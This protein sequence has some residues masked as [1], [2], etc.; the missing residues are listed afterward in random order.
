L[1]E[2]DFIQHSAWLRI[3]AHKLY[4]M[5]VIAKWNSCVAVPN[6]EDDKYF[7]LFGVKADE[8]SNALDIPTKLARNRQWQSQMRQQVNPYIDYLVSKIRQKML[9]DWQVQ[10]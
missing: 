4:L 2:D 9:L 5:D 10:S 7:H 1:K 3:I 6:C 8:T